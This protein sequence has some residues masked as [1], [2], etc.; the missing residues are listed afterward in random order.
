[1]FFCDQTQYQNPKKVSLL[2]GE[3]AVPPAPPANDGQILYFWNGVEPDD[4]SAVLQ[5]VLQWGSTPAGG[6]AY[7]AVASWYFT[8]PPRSNAF[9]DSP[10][11]AGM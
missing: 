1:M 3:W 9:S 10:F 2:Y 5:P 6:G 7:W 8:L 11:L 4:N